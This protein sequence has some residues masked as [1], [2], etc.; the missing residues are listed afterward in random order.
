MS[1]SP[2][3]A[4]PDEEAVA[5]RVAL[6]ALGILDTPPE[7]EFDDVVLIAAEMCRA[8]VALVSLLDLDRQWFKARRGFDACETPIGQ[9]V[10]AHAVAGR[11][12]LV[13]PD[14]TLDPRTSQNPL[15]TGPPHIRF[16]AGAPLVTAADV[17]IGTLCVIDSVPRPEGLTDGQLASLRALARQVILLLEL[18]RS[19]AERDHS[20]VVQE[21]QASDVLARAVASEAA[22]A[23]LQD[24][25]ARARSAEEAGQIGTFEIDRAAGTMIMSDMACRLYGLPASSSYSIAAV[26]A[27]VDD[28]DR[29]VVL[30]QATQRDGTA[31]S[32]VDYRVVRAD[33]GRRRWI[34]RR[35]HFVG[36][37]G[38][39]PAKVIGTL[40]DITELK[41]TADRIA[42]LLAI[43]DSL[44]EAT[45]VREIANAAAISLG[46]TLDV[47]RAGYAAI[48]LRAGSFVVEADWT[49]STGASLIG[50]HLTSAFAATMDRLRGGSS[51]VVGDVEAAEWLGA[52][53]TSY[54]AMTVRSQVMI[55]FVLHGD[56]IG[57]VFVHDAAA[58]VWSAED[59]DFV[60][61]IADRTYAALA[62]VRA[63]NEQKILNLE[64]SHRLK[65]SLATVQGIAMQTLRAVPDQAPVQ[66]FHQRLYVLSQAHE[67]L[68]QETWSAAPIKAIVLGVLAVHTVPARASMTGPDL[69]LGPR[70]TLSFSMLLHELATNALKYGALSTDVGHVDV[71]WTVE[72]L[73]PETDLVV[74]WTEHGGPPVV[75]PRHKGFGSRL[76]QMGLAG[77]GDVETR[78]AQ[79]GLQA[80]FRAPLSQLQLS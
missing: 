59:I 65:N 2:Q 10:C 22:K 24:A 57:A 61:S 16:Y 12:V 45:T 51:L 28:A 62:K 77:T 79:S 18:R 33:D 30:S 27:L 66:V 78:Y 74:T 52:D 25:H 64:L 5:R 46:R 49:G 63:E 7:P 29:D 17:A 15:V 75:A 23:T 70:A 67:L 13:I 20:L 37:R 60:R 42:A 31:A 36:G 4:V 26:E 73:S 9:A 71:S 58:R 47:L 56:L 39:A 53:R 80:V 6:S 21:H 38:D 14:L 69:K 72:G 48:D 68:M 41:A 40:E 55:P 8:P 11:D 54:A 32:R 1:R 34:A 43:G 50:R 19:V 44:R 3:P 35:A 76:I